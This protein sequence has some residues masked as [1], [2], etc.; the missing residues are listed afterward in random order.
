MAGTRPAMTNLPTPTGT[1]SST[2]TSERASKSASGKNFRDALIKPRE[3][4][5][6]LLVSGTALSRLRA[7]EDERVGGFVALSVRPWRSGSSMRRW[8]TPAS[9][10]RG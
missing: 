3:K 6:G 7:S 8:T 2:P 10:S 4:Y 1:H 5:V 9:R